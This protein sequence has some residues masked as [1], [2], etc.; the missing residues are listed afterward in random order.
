MNL[1]QSAFASHPPVISVGKY[2]GAVDG[3]PV[4][5]RVGCS[6]GKL[7]GAMVGSPIRLGQGFGEQQRGWK[8]REHKLE[9]MI[10]FATRRPEQH[11]WNLLW[12]VCKSLHTTVS[13]SGWHRLCTRKSIADLWYQ[14]SIAV[15]PK[16][17][18]YFDQR[19]T[20]SNV[21]NTRCFQLISWDL[22]F[23][24]AVLVWARVEHSNRSVSTRTRSRIMKLKWKWLDFTSHR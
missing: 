11:I 13:F 23:V 15:R 9:T 3:D 8:N 5:L 22:L 20:S 1:E 19:K 17:K 18:D 21:A 2:V 10:F 6:E 12:A 4:G 7:V 16:S 24:S 14:M